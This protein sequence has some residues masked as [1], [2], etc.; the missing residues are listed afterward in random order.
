MRKPVVPALFA[1]FL[2]CAIISA[3]AFIYRRYVNEIEEVQDIPWTDAH[4]VIDIPELMAGG[5][6]LSTG[7]AYFLLDKF[8]KDNG[9]NATITLPEQDASLLDS[10]KAG[11]IDLVCIPSSRGAIKDKLLASEELDGLFRWIVRPNDLQKLIKADSW[12]QHYNA[13]ER[14]D[15]LNRR[16]MVRTNKNFRV[17]PYDSLIRAVAVRNGLNPSMFK[18]VVLRESRFHIEALS[19]SGAKGLCQLMP[20]IIRKFEVA[21]P[22]DPEMNLEGGARLLKF[23]YGRYSRISE[24]ERTRFVLSAYNGGHGMIERCMQYADSIGLDPNIWDD[25]K[26]AMSMML[27][28]STKT[29][30]DSLEDGS[31][32]QGWKQTEVYADAVISAY[33]PGTDS[34]GRIDSRNKESR[35][36]KEE[37][38]G[39][40]SDSVNDKD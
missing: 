25:V 13:S 38:N 24:P 12:I 30:A 35:N 36:Q 14:R 32:K 5:V 9:I 31:D 10:L 39:D 28:D 21:N 15:S 16:F 20:V 7:Y 8:F 6:P 23:L 1:L 3:F 27:T 2:V 18:A 33:L 17:S 34:L 11:S 37:H 26:L 19:P 22:L 29:A 4:C 40:E